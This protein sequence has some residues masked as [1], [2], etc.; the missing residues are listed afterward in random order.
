M[1]LSLLF[2]S[3]MVFYLLE[4]LIL[5]TVAVWYFKQEKKS[6]LQTQT[7]KHKGLTASQIMAMYSVVNKI[8]REQN[9]RK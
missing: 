6:K 8:K 9:L 5:L 1:E 4:I 3:F 7:I 2:E